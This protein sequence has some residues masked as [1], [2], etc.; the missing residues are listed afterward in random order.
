MRK[1]IFLLG[2][3]VSLFAVPTLKFYCGVTMAKA[4][5]MIANKFEAKTGAKIIIIKGGS[6]SLYKKILHS[7]SGDL[8]LP[9]ADKYIKDD[10]NGLFVYTRLVGYNRP[11]ILVQK[12]NPK[13]ITGLDDF[14]N[15]AVRVVIGDKH[16]GS[17]GKI[18]KKILTTYKGEKFYQKVYNRAKKVPTSVEIVQAL[19]A[20]MA[21]TSINWKA[22]AFDGD[23]SKYVD[24]I[25]IPYIAPKQ[26]LILA[27]IKYSLHPELAKQFVD[28]AT[29]AENKA[30]MKSKGF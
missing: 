1:L 6:G 22:A 4:M 8:Y 25:N 28:F 15:P 11:V 24:Y 19:K 3:S 5:R 2:L 20:D 26:K 18:T 23:N 29:Q 12:G 9:G 17:V 10:Q 16:S 7:Q 27:V 14:L 30:L 13:G 21:D